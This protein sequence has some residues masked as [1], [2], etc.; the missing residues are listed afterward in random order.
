[1]MMM[2]LG[3]CLLTVPFFIVHD[4]VWFNDHVMCSK[5]FNNTLF[6]HVQQYNPGLYYLTD[7]I[8]CNDML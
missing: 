8:Y 3:C 6:A 4:T 5:M 1:M 2:R 7:A